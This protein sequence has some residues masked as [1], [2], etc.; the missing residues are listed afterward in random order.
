[1]I[2]LV[3]EEHFLLDVVDKLP[4]GWQMLI[5]AAL[6]FFLL[7]SGIVSGN[8]VTSIVALALVLAG[9]SA[10]LT[11]HVRSMN[12]MK[13]TL[14]IASATVALGL[15]AIGYIMTGSLILGILTLFTVAMIFVVFTLSYLLP[16]I[17][18]RTEANQSQLFRILKSPLVE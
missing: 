17:R 8:V 11:S 13:Q 4:R 7:L 6:G 3:A 15:F 5:W 2:L 10:F 16:R 14:E 12:R 9:L 18:S 1:M